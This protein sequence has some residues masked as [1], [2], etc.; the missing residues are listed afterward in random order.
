MYLECDEGQNTLSLMRRRVHHRAKHGTNGKGDSL[1]GYRGKDCII[2]VPPGTIVRDED[3]VLAGELNRH[4][5]RLLVARGG[6]GGR[7]N[8]YFKTPRNV[9]PAFAE[10]GENGIHR[11]LN[12]ELKLVA[13]VGLIGVPNAGKS[14]LL[15]SS[16]NAKPKIADYPFTTVIPNLGVCDVD[17]DQNSG[18]KG[19]VLA[20][21]PGLLEGAH[22]G[23]GLGLAFLRHVQRCRVL[24]HVINGLSEDPIGDFQAIN[25]ELELFNPK[26]AKKTQVVVVNKI[27]VPEVRDLLPDFT[28]E[29]TK[30]A[31]HNRVIGISAATGERVEELMRRVRKVVAS[32]P[33][34]SEM[35]LFTDEEERVSFEDAVR[36]EFDVLTDERFP[37]Q[38]RVVGDEVERIVA[39]TNWDYYEATA[40]FQRILD[41]RG[42]SAALK[43]HG[44]TEGDL[45]MIGDWD[46]Q[47]SQHKNEWLADYDIGEDALP[48]RRPG[49]TKFK[50]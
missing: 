43:D 4:G 23:K 6:K 8:E 10:K 41:A 39:M 2:P 47:Y 18:G 9:A 17:S 40:R 34:Q 19:L 20:D 16:S 27:D 49:P 1:H 31:G 50:A 28:A 44:A 12:I 42:I 30:L 35:E 37:G 36:K 13:D 25:Q 11:W 33:A 32:L 24:I 5:Q 15:S 38:F 7:G 45:V 29:L 3:G 48:Q 46:F 26:L 14:T 21:I 22:T